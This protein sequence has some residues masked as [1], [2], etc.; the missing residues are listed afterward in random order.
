MAERK[1]YFFLYADDFLSGVLG[2]PDGHVGVYMKLLCMCWSK[3]G[4]TLQ[5]AI[6]VSRDDAAIEAVLESKFYLDEG[7]KFRNRKLE[8]VR[9]FTAKQSQNAA[10]RTAKLPAKTQPNGQPNP[11]PHIHIQNHIQKED[12][13]ESSH[14]K[15]GEPAS[16]PTLEQ[17]KE[18]CQERGSGIDPE[19]FH[20]HYTA[21]GWKQSSG[22]PIRDWRAAVRT[23]ERN[24]FSGIGS[25][26]EIF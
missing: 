11:Q 21:N 19:Q 17:V 3:G 2:M 1:P 8:K 25:K 10:K 4:I 24:S 18:Y 9:Q 7:G 23:W 14:K 5:E 6:S 15:R 12:S 20:D 16:R 13:K 22:N 26:K